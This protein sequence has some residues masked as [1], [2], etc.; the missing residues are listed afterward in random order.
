MST[1]MESPV[2]LTIQGYYRG[3]SI[4]ITKRDAETKAQPLI[5]QSMEAIDYMVKLGIKPSWNPETNKAAL[6]EERAVESNPMPSEDSS[7]EFPEEERDRDSI[8]RPGWCAIHRIKMYEK[9]GQYGKYWSHGNRETGYCN[10]KGFKKAGT[11]P[12]SSYRSDEL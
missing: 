7:M 1:G 8:V 12:L 11:K 9:E 10:G 5:E 6:G 3:F 2:S 4:L